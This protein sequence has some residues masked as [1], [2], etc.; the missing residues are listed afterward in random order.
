MCPC[1][2]KQYSK[3]WKLISKNIITASGNKC[4]LCFAPNECTVNR[5]TRV[6][7]PWEL[8]HQGGGKETKIVLTVHHIDG[9]KKNNSRHNLIALCARCHLRIDIGRHIKNRAEKKRNKE[10]GKCN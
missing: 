5:S 10:A 2:Y 6:Q 9:D 7:Y 1:D 8:A 4:E 3:D